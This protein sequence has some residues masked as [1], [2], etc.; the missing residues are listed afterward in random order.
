MFTSSGS[1]SSP[2]Q[3]PEEA[4]G[5][6]TRVV[7]A[8]RL[9][10]QLSSALHQPSHVVLGR[11]FTSPGPQLYRSLLATKSKATVQLNFSTWVSVPVSIL[12]GVVLSGGWSRARGALIFI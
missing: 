2:H 8:Q 9:G 6:S 4:A 7:G 5:E 11:S 12:M 3:S 1:G 10:P